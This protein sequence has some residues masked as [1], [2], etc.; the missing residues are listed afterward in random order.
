[1]TAAVGKMPGAIGKMAPRD[2]KMRLVAG[3]DRT[4]D[5]VEGRKQGDNAVAAGYG[6]K[7]SNRGA[8]EDAK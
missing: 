1:M 6:R 4:R 5:G 7:N 8:A 3:D 2:G